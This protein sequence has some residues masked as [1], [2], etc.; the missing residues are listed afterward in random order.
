M[1]SARRVVRS[2]NVSL[3]SQV[4]ETI[5]RVCARWPFCSSRSPCGA[6]VAKRWLCR[7]RRL[8]C[9]L[10]IP[11]HR[12]AGSARP[13]L[14]GL[15]DRLL[16]P[17]SATYPSSGRAHLGGDRRRCV[18]APELRSRQGR[19]S[20]QHPRITVRGELPLR[21]SRHQLLRTGPASLADPALLVLGVEEQFY[22]VW[23]LVLLTIVV[24]R[25][26]RR[27][28]SILP[29]PPRS[30]PPSGGLRRLLGDHR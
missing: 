29:V 7:G 20:G 24:W 23:P 16:C 1:S 3:V 17:P 11:D 8:L 30:T 10:R 22:L 19:A 9:P 13:G 5:S 4:I 25:T 28:A 6:L 2:W 18:C 14:A 27:R 21:K 12:L 15:P 26:L